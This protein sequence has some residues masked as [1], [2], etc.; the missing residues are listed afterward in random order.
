MKIS[1]SKT[2]EIIENNKL[3]IIYEKD[4]IADTKMNEKR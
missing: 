4:E 1:G 2:W 3:M